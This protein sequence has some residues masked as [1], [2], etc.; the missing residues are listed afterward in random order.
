MTEAT[1]AVDE[2]ARTKLDRAFEPLFAKAAAGEHVTHED[3]MAANHAAGWLPAALMMGVGD[4]ADLTGESKANVSRILG[5]AP[6]PPGWEARPPCYQ[7][8]SG[9]VWYAPEAVRFI[10]AYQKSPKTPPG[11]KPGVT[12]PHPLGKQVAAER[13]AAKAAEMAEAGS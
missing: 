9:R 10:E 6:L 3:L 1:A 4:L 11:R 13:A 7:L 5:E 12:Y 2:A 8:R